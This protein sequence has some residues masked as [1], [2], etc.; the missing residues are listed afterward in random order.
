MSVIP[1]QQNDELQVRIR[2][3]AEDLAFPRAQVTMCKI[4]AE[5]RDVRNVL[6]IITNFPK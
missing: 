4:R 3:Y 1:C 2:E 6:G 5:K